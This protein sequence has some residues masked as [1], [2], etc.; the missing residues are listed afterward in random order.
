[1][2]RRVVPLK[3]TAVSKESIESDRSA[4]LIA[5][6]TFNPWLKFLRNVGER[7][8]FTVQNWKDF[9]FFLLLKVMCV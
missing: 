4:H 5:W 9:N 8:E 3:L 7:R 1:M 6:R 2:W